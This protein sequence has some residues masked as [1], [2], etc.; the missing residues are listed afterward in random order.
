M[1]DSDADHTL[2]DLTMSNILFNTVPLL[3]GAMT[4]QKWKLYIMAYIMSTRDS[5]IFQK[6]HLAKNSI[7]QNTYK[8]IKN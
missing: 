2:L 7:N 1:N 4:F 5:Y 8:M 3:D 6:D